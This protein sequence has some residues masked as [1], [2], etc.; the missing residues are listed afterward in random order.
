MTPIEVA[1]AALLI[2]RWALTI[3]VLYLGR[4]CYNEAIK[5]DKWAQKN[6]TPEQ[7][8]LA[9]TNR[10]TERNRWREQLGFAV[11]SLLGLEVLHLDGLD[12]TNIVGS[13]CV[14][15][16]QLHIA[17]SSAVARARRLRALHPGQV[18]D[19]TGPSGLGE[20]EQRGGR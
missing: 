9:K 10:R 18:A 2:A 11:M 13:V 12:F 4:Y 6:G 17:D 20:H 19:C 3:R 15:W 1:Y 8:D 14:I 5:D 16:I 7:K